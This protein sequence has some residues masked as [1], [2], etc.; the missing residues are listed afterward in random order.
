MAATLIMAACMGDGTPPARTPAV[1][2]TA[3]DGEP[4]AALDALIER[5]LVLMASVTTVAVQHSDDCDAAAAG[6]DALGRR[7]GADAVNLLTADPRWTSDAALQRRVGDDVR[8]QAFVDSLMG[9]LHCAADHRPLE[10]ALTRRGL[11]P[12]KIDSP[13]AA[14]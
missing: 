10:A 2:P 9:L 5:A 8:A 14:E 1:A 11:A 3:A 7:P 4:P 6:I 13:A 12:R